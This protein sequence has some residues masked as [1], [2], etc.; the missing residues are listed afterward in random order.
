MYTHQYLS[1]NSH[2]IQRRLESVG[3]RFVVANFD[4]YA[5]RLVELCDNLKD[6][7]LCKDHYENDIHW[8]LLSFLLE[9]SRNPVAG[10]EANRKEICL[11]KNQ[12]IEE[13]KTATVAEKEDS[14]PSARTE[15]HVERAK[16][17]SNED[18]SVSMLNIFSQKCSY[19]SYF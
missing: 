3:E 11:T 10:L 2:E 14:G 9:V 7:P 15:H 18:L 5:Q 6:D 16:L 13:N 17:D 19:F 8:V 1:V 12:C 4:S